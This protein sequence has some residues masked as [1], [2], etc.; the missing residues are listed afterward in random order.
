MEYKLIIITALLMVVIITP[1]IVYAAAASNSQQ[2]A[3][4]DGTR[5]CALGYQY[6]INQHSNAGHHSSAYMDTYNAAFVSCHNPTSI[7]TQTQAQSANPSSTCSVLIGSC[8][9]GQ[10]TTQAQNTQ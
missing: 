6:W 8:N 10:T 9:V 1:S 3:W 4:D 7:V 2:V 5:D